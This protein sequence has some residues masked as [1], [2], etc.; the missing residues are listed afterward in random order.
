MPASAFFDTTIL[1]YGFSEGE[2]RKRDVARALIA[3][4]SP[5]VSTQVLSE[6]A[7]VLTGKFRQPFGN[8]AEVVRRIADNYGLIVVDP[9]IVCAAVGIAQR[10][11]LGFYDSQI[12]AAALAGGADVLYTEDLHHGQVID[13]VLTI[14]SPFKSEAHENRRRYS[15]ASRTEPRPLSRRR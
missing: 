15:T 10:F 8:V 1:V 6:L 14:L 4:C 5:I 7:N 12:I 2:P 9:D 11:R 3:E 13:G